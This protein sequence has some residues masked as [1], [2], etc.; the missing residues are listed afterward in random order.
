[1]GYAPFAKGWMESILVLPTSIPGHKPGH[2]ENIPGAAVGGA[3]PC[4]GAAA[5]AGGAGVNAGGTRA[6]NSAA[7]VCFYGILILFILCSPYCTHLGDRCV[8]SLISFSL[9][10]EI[11]AAF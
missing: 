2:N 8:R 6:G 11:V 9:P 4:R 5:A 10:Y 3:V 7:A 1:M